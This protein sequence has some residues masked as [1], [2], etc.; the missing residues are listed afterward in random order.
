MRGYYYEPMMKRY[1]RIIHASTGWLMS[2]EGR[3]YIADAINYARKRFGRAE[4]KKFH[5]AMIYVGT[6]YPKLRVAI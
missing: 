2:D 4:A 3:K 1:A 5:D 6:I